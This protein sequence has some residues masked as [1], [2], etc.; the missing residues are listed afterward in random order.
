MFF[1]S[2]S[3]KHDKAPGRGDCFIAFLLFCCHRRRENRGETP[4]RISCS[5]ISR[6]VRKLGYGLGILGDG[7]MG[8]KSERK[9]AFSFQSD[10]LF[11]LSSV[12]MKDAGLKVKVD[13][14]DH[15]SYLYLTVYHER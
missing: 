3:G 1:P 11:T 4:D 7:E 8:K 10:S 13:P 15:F 9:D 2:A 6:I 5:E 12:R 14:R